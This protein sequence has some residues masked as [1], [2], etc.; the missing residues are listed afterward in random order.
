MKFIETTMKYYLFVLLLLHPLILQGQSVCISSCYNN[1]LFKDIDNKLTI[2][3]ENQPCE[4]IFLEIDNGN[5]QFYNCTC[6]INPTKIGD[7]KLIAKSIN[8]LDTIIVF[9]K[10]FSV[11]P[12]P[13]PVAKIFGISGGTISSTN[14]RRQ[15]GINIL[16]EKTGLQI[17]SELLSYHIFIIRSDSVIYSKHILGNKFTHDVSLIL[18]NLIKFDVVVFSNLIVKNKNNSTITNIQP[19]EFIIE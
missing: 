8:S 19:I 9:E 11:E 2:I 7:A 3:F 1:V 18:E 14:L 13:K 17:D 10:I 6:I 15:K 12:I 5:I 16:Y 4:N